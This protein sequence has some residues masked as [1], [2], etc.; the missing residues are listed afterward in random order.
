MDNLCGIKG[1]FI[2]ILGVCCFKEVSPKS[3]NR[4]YCRQH[5]YVFSFIFKKKVTL[6]FM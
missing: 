6:H 1:S 3:T 4:N 5:F 2:M